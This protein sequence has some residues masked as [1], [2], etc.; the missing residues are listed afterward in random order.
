M[1]NITALK[2]KY[3]RYYLPVIILS[4]LFLFIPYLGSVH[5]FDWDEINFAESAREMI[6]TGNYHRVQIN[7]EPFWEKPPLFFWLQVVC[8]KAFSINEFA[9]RL[10]NAIFGLITLITFYF[11]GKKYKSALF[12]FLWALCYLGSFLPHIYFKSGIIDPVFN[13]FIF[14][15]I[16]FMH[17]S[18]TQTDRS[19]VLNIILAGTFIGLANLTKGPV[20]LLIF[21]LTFFIYFI[22]K[23]FKGFPS[24]KNIFIFIGCFTVVSFFWFGQEVINNGVWFLKE[25]LNYQ[26][27]LF[28]HPVAEHGEPF[29]YHF[30][31]I[32][33]GCFP[34]SMLAFPGLFKR[35]FE[36]SD[37]K[38]IMKILFW[39]VLILFSI[40]TTKIIHY[41][42][43]TYFPL[44]F[45]AA[46]YVHYL[47]VTRNKIPPYIF[48]LLSLVAL[49]LATVLIGLP[50]I[51]SHKEML[52]PHL[53][54]PFAAAS[55][56]VNVSWSGY[57]YLIGLAYLFLLIIS[58]IMLSKGKFVKG[59]LLLFYSTA[60]CL[61]FY[62]SAVI[63]KIEKFSQGPAITFYQSLIGKN[64][65][66]VPFGF[67]SYAHYFYFEKSFSPHKDQDEELSRLLTGNIDKPAYFVVKV[68]NA[69]FST[70][71]KNCRLIKKEGGFLFY[72]R[73]PN[74]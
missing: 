66:V 32:F 30:V 47:I 53:N 49:V 69:E 33:F 63:P 28:L 5:L 3:D 52:V 23:K 37:F 18:L 9:A 68:G 50:F 45:L 51:A 56:D 4:A 62:L 7:F 67:K 59:F 44:S 29:Y 55:L 2:G 57:E 39:V 21:L 16:Y 54:D 34:I 10:P 15:G 71:C 70:A 26:A 73:E 20:G 43:M 35:N 64:V 12:G 13:Y 60:I 11:F 6:V 31:V 22:L 41:S 36:A 72:I 58:F 65:S 25:F 74:K 19:T 24:L 38:K 42:S 46:T 8:M 27:D 40:T 48:I 14:L 1:E 61:F 17:R